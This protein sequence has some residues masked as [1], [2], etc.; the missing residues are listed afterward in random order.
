MERLERAELLRDH[1]RRMIRE[2]DPAR[3]D[4]D[5]AGA[6][7]D[8]RDHD[9]C[10]GARDPR[11][12]V[13][14]REP[15][16][17]VAPAL[18]VL[19][20]VERARKRGCRRRASTIGARSRIESGSWRVSDNPPPT[21]ATGAPAASLVRV[22]APDG[23]RPIQLTDVITPLATRRAHRRDRSS[24]LSADPRPLEHRVD[25]KHDDPRPRCRHEDHGALGR[26][27][28]DTVYDLTGSS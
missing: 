27:A 11:R 12:V 4:A 1:E 10:R 21:I 19:R 14:L 13:V 26:P 22:I 28:R 7:G 17:L 9:G 20:E 24:W 18:G 8:V 25:T 2:H 3:P 6:G 16:A 15:E 5:R 23:G